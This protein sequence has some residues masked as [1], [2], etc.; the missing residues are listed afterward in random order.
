MCVNRKKEKFNAVR[1][2]PLVVYRDVTS[3]EQ[4]TNRGPFL[5]HAILAPNEFFFKIWLFGNSESAH[6]TA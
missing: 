2:A 4:R 6:Q 3:A 1:R 5:R